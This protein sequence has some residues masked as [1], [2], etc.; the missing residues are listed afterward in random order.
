MSDTCGGHGGKKANGDPCTR[1]GGGLCWQHSEEGQAQK[2]AS[3]Q[4]I[5]KKVLELLGGGLP[6]KD[7]CQG[8]GKDESTIWRWRQTDVVFGE[9]VDQIM[10]GAQLAAIQLRRVEA[11]LFTRILVGTA[12]QTMTIFWLVNTAARVAKARGEDLRWEHVYNVHQ[13]LS[14]GVSYTV[15]LETARER[16]EEAEAEG[17]L[18]TEFLPEPVAQRMSGNGGKP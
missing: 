3:L 11:S 9:A 10:D 17:R 13:T 15:A 18:A 4:P 12:G 2:D 1:N 5:K 8:L 7:I 16:L 14:G 6:F